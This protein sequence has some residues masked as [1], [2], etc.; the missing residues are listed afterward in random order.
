M[1]MKKMIINLI[2][3]FIYFIYIMTS[4]SG[5]LRTLRIST[6][7]GTRT[8][9]SVV[10]SSSSAGAGSSRRILSYYKNLY[11]NNLPLFYLNIFGLRYGQ[12]PILAL[13]RTL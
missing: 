7:G 8:L 3:F 12:F 2:N 10:T 6:T 4:G 1:K 11:E 13:R 9:G 5:S